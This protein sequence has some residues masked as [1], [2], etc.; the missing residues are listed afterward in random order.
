M[1]A[2]TQ[3]L[4]QAIQ[5]MPWTDEPEG[6]DEVIPPTA[7]NSDSSDDDQPGEL[8]F[9]RELVTDCSWIATGQPLASSI[10]TIYRP[11]ARS[12]RQD[13]VH[14]DASGQAKGKGKALASIE[15]SDDEDPDSV[16]DDGEDFET[17]PIDTISASGYPPHEEDAIAAAAKRALPGSVE[18]L[19]QSR[20]LIMTRSASLATVRIKR[21][22][23]LA[24]KLREVFGL[25]DI[26]E[27]VAGMCSQ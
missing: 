14:F 11:I 10:H 25:S 26:S 17:T 15:A 20:R 12:R 1:R 24:E 9:N 21:R 13:S 4:I 8:F 27:V 23:R 5:A 18:G 3:T 7:I 16:S 2:G 22:A 6:Y 19:V